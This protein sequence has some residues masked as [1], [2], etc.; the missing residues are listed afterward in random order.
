LPAD[1][2]H[3]P[4]VAPAAAAHIGRIADSLSGVSPLLSLVPRHV[5]HGSQLVLSEA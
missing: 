5:E 4:I 3:G 1:R 2:R